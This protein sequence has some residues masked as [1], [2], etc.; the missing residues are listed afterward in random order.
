[1][2]IAGWQA[3]YQIPRLL[4][5][6][7][8]HLYRWTLKP[9][10]G[11]NCRHM[12]TCSAYALEAIDKNGAWRGFWLTIS[13]LSRCHPWGTHGHDPVPDLRREHHPFAPWRYGR[14]TGKHLHRA[15]SSAPVTL[16]EILSPDGARRVVIQR[17]ENGFYGFEEEYF[18][19]DHFAEA[20]FDPVAQGQW[21]PLS[22]DSFS[23]C[24]TAATAE[25]EARGRI[26]W[27]RDSLSS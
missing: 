26:S 15:S 2:T 10:V 8:I 5:K 22:E 16:K 6:A 20:G 3:L 14:W 13:R 27:L 18:C 11:W 25:R 1:M 4:L 9:L 19:E 24:D 23:L 7:P 17:Y 21:C 12:P